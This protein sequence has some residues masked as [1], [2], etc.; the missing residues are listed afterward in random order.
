[1]TMSDREPTGGSLDRLD[2]DLDLLAGLLDAE[3]IDASGATTIARRGPDAPVPMSFS[4]ELL[5]L[6]DRATPGL[7]AY[8]LPITRRLRGPLDVPALERALTQL[9][10][11]HE[12]LRARFAEI[13][14]GPRL[15]IDEAGL[16]AIAQIDLSALPL[17]EREREAERVA[18]ERAR[19]PFDLTR[20]HLFRASLVRLDAADHVLVLQSHHIV[21][22]GWS[23]GVLF[24]E[25]DAAYSA[26]RAGRE[27]A[28][29][30]VSLQF[31]DFAIWQ[32]EHLAG[33]RLESLL[34][35]WRG[36]LG[37]ASEPLGLATDRPRPAAPTF[38]GARAT[39]VLSADESARLRELAQ[40]HDATLYMVLL[41]GYASVLHRYTGRR[42]VLVG[43]GS[44]GRTLRETESLVGYLNNTLVQR[45]DFSG[46]PTFTALLG[47]VR[48]SALAAYDHQD[49]P[50]EKLVLELRRG[51][52]RL[53]PAPLFEVVLTMQDA[54]PSSLALDGVVVEPYGVDM[55]GTKFDLTL[56]VVH[57]PDGLHLTAQYRSDLFESAT[58]ER[59]LGHLRELLL[60]AGDTPSLRVSALP[61]VTA[62]ER[63][64]LEAWNATAVDEGPVESIV[65]LVRAQAARVPERAAVV[66]A[67]GTFTYAQ[68]IARARGIARRLEAA[69]VVRGDRVGLL[70]DRSA[71]AVAGLLGILEAGAAFVPL[72]MEAPVARLERQLAESG[73]RIVVTSSTLVAVAPP[74][75]RTVLVDDPLEST[76]EL[77]PPMASADDLAYVLYTSGSTGVPKGVAVT[78]AN[79]VHYARAVSRVLAGM[80]PDAA[81][82]GLAALDG[83]RFGMVSTM[84]ADL[85]YT[86]LLGA[87][88]AGGTL[89]ILPKDAATEPAR[90]AEIVAAQ[91]LDILKIT[92][93]HLHALTSNRTGR[94]LAALLPRRWLVLGG[95]A[96]RPDLARTLL[97]TGACRVLNHYGPTE[98]TVGACTF[99]VTAS[100]L[101]AALAQGA[102]TVPIGQPLANTR[103][104]VVDA[105]GTEQPI[106]V[107]GELVLAGAGVASGYL[108]RAELSAE[109][110]AQRGE[111][112]AYR[113]GDRV[114][115]LAS[116]ALEFQGRVDDQVKVRGYRVELGEIEQALRVLPGVAQAVVAHRDGGS[117]EPVLAAYVVPKVEGYASSHGERVTPDSLRTALSAQLPEYM[118]PAVVLLLDSLPLTAN[119][120]VDRAALPVP[121]VGAHADRYVAPK[122]PVEEQLAAI[123]SEVLKRD[124]IGSRDNFLELGGHSLLAI[125]VLGKI[126]KSFGVRL[127]L[128]TLFDAPTIEQLAA[129]VESTRATNAPAAAGIGVA[130]R[131]AY[132]IG[133]TAPAGETGGGAGGSTA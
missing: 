19:A 123:W 30:A 93:G 51:V 5:W 49:V 42:D 47:R 131:D 116:G 21:L 89:H 90:F 34:A 38:A 24:R 130:S 26:Y 69:G 128:R 74:D 57:R 64:T 82:D 15:V 124:R 70:L 9:V 111:L 35:F 96:L 97:A 76:H 10:A 29:P 14:G 103:A 121:G 63:T 61:L 109:R 101:D 94:D 55:A 31:G 22:D 125:R 40:R 11:R 17:D 81:G 32:R 127:P 36:Q 79:A 118:V 2:D 28:L 20:E 77:A 95:E 53:S 50:L 84:A 91:P 8:N 37:D 71:D 113:T 62:A 27:P 68:L 12:S 115:R 80:R 75:T 43:S 59:F 13:D 18:R 7:T 39:L 3:G 56:L 87:L 83:L 107:P 25:L 88:L 46:D 54:M 86:S 119:G 58:I 129:I 45:A 133:K 66:G 104:Y 98:T 41:A 105:H 44:A 120:K 99:E 92:P 117:G 100:S 33:P 16:V 52:E 114:R 48:E 132:R 126:S 78:H 60:A 110:F 23:M 122:S 4:Q 85:G 112:R 72:S 65:S 1:M 6:L 106:G 67:D 102:Q 108:G 73:A